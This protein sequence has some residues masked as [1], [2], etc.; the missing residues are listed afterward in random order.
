MYIVESSSN[1]SLVS[2]SLCRVLEG[3]ELQQNIFKNTNLTHIYDWSLSCMQSLPRVHLLFEI[4]IL[5]KYKTN[6]CAVCTLPFPDITTEIP[7]PRNRALQ[8]ND[9]WGNK[10]SMLWYCTF[11]FYQCF[12]RPCRLE[13]SC[14]KYSKLQ[15]S[16]KAVETWSL[17]HHNNLENCTSQSL[18]QA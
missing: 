2:S 15:K 16:L 10:W 1:H 9:G 12:I 8:E 18:H 4:S 13:H 5:K 17:K 6:I 7:Y 14:N 11:T 3:I